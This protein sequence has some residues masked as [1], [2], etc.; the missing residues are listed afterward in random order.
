MHEFCSACSCYCNEQVSPSS[1]QRWT[2]LLGLTKISHVCV[3]AIHSPMQC[4]NY[5]EG[6]VAGS[7]CEP[8]CKTKE[9]K[10]TKCLGAHLLKLYVFEAEMNGKPVIIKS[11]RSNDHHHNRMKFLNS[12]R[13][14]GYN[15]DKSPL[16]KSSDILP[17]MKLTREQFIEQANTTLFYSIAGKKYTERTK[18]VL[19][20]VVTECDLHGDGVLGREEIE[21]CWRIVET[22]EYTIALLVEENPALFKVF[23][24]CG[25]LYAEEFATPL[26]SK[27][28]IGTEGFLV[29]KRPWNLRAKLAISILD[30][31]E[32]LEDTPYGALHYCD[33]KEANI[34]ISEKQ[35]LMVA[36]SIDLDSGWFGD[37]N[38]GVKFQLKTY[39]TS[40]T[41]DNDCRFIH[42]HSQ[43]NS[44]SHTCSAR[45][46]FNNFQVSFAVGQEYAT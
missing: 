37:I 25:E 14:M 45:M 35:G 22:E 26:D 7:L 5:S 42:C 23:G 41:T 2:A 24:L 9:L 21:R 3:H 8:L 30:M 36:K 34:G 31:L 11:I 20:Q 43:C 32:E 1:L 10:F 18:K 6:L 39:N 38:G 40:C 12:F 15:P 33:V 4:A 16:P 19:E 27:Q 17:N 28:Y 13:L 29:S 46:A 44:T